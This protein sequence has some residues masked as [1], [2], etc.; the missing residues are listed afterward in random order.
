[1]PTL[2]PQP[3]VERVF[4]PSDD[5]PEIP[6]EKRGWI[7]IKDRL[8]LQQIAEVAAMGIRA[9]EAMLEVLAR[10]ITAWNLTDESGE[11]APINAQNIN[12]MDP[13]DFGLLSD[14]FYNLNSQSS[15]EV[16]PSEKKASSAT[17]TESV[18]TQNAPQTIT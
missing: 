4:L 11:I 5:K 18:A 3:K 7:E 10:M 1:M 9:S 12:R 15:K 2:L 17:S 14:R 8:Q 13:A 6:P 16:A